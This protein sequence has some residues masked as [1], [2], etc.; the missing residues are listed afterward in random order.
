MQ[1]DAESIYI[2]HLIEKLWDAGIEYYSRKYYY[3]DSIMGEFPE[4]VWIMIPLDSIQYILS[5]EHD[6]IEN[7]I[8]YYEFNFIEDSRDAD[9]PS[10]LVSGYTLSEKAK[11]KLIKKIEVY[12]ELFKQSLIQYNKTPAT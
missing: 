11:S 4:Y 7:F 1:I 12:H 8:R 5:I 9:I 10:L 3:D 6:F 2:M